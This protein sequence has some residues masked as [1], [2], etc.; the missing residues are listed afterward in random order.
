MDFTKPD[1]TDA[2]KLNAILWRNAKGNLPM[3]A[4]EHKP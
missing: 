2:R 4:A 1:A 3:P